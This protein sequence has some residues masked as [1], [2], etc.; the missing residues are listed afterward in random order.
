MEVTAMLEWNRRSTATTS[1]GGAGGA[2]AEGSLESKIAQVSATGSFREPR[3]CLQRKE[4]ER[5]A[6]TVAGD[7]ERRPRS[8]W[9][10]S[11]IQLLR[12]KQPEME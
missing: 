9:G 3:G 1:S 10:N 7:E 5:E 6:L 4:S 2:S 12:V 11:E 8:I